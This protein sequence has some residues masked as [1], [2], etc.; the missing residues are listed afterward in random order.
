M[1]K[2]KVNS[3]T[4]VT[5]FGL[6]G[7]SLEMA[8]GSE[9]TIEIF[10]NNVPVID[11]AFKYAKGGFIPGGM[12]KNKKYASDFVNATIPIESELEAILYDPQTSGGLLISVAC[13]DANKLQEEL[14]QN[15]PC[16]SIIGQVTEKKDKPVCLL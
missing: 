6:L 11:S 5:G 13:E 16:A 1:V 14:A 3:C 12:H 4:G 8:K 7:H 10:C 9:K 15:L 2:Y